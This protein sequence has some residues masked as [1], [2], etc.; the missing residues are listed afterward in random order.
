MSLPYVSGKGAELPVGR[1]EKLNVREVPVFLS[2]ITG[3]KG[4]GVLRSL[5]VST[6]PC[7]CFFVEERNGSKKKLLRAG[8]NG[9]SKQVQKA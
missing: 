3:R 6:G 5:S 7:F 4:V 8:G 2:N 9:Q 1:I